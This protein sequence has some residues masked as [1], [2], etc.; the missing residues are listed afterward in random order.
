M[1]LLLLYKDVVHVMTIE[2][3]EIYRMVIASFALIDIFYLLK[4]IEIHIMEP[5]NIVH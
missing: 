1:D 2:W 4:L 3:M 5:Y